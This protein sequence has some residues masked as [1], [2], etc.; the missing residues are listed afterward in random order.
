MEYEGVAKTA[1]R[2]GISERSVRNYCAQGRVPGAFLAGKTWRIPRDSAK[3]QRANAR[4]ARPLLDVLRAEKTA[5]I[6]GGI[7]HRLQVDMAYN[8]NHIEGS[9]LTHEQTRYIFETRTVG[10]SNDEAIHVD[11]IIEASNHFR[12]F[13]LALD[14]AT[15]RLS[16]K[17]VRELH[18]ILKEGTSDAA[19]DWFALGDWK[20]FP[21]EVGGRMTTLPERVDAEM[22]ELVASYE[23]GGT[24]DFDDLLDFHV[25]FERIH[26]FQDGNGRVGRLILLKEC[27]R[28]G[29][30]PFIITDGLKLFYYRGLARW[31]EER[32]WLRDTCLTGQDA[33][34]EVLE[35]FRVDVSD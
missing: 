22:R 6:R 3:P 33:M 34:R 12:A 11:D 8:S 19:Q 4:A 35:R 9:T 2:W 21:N 24:H 1:D 25:R 32:G 16:I 15:T 31:D 20:R 23:A 5:G 10:L 13:D 26:P 28:W 30:V 14:R 18:H 17:L 29:V 7:Y 27:L